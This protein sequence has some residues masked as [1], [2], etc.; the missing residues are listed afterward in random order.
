MKTHLKKLVLLTAIFF[1]L[2]AGRAQAW[3]DCRPDEV[4]DFQP[5]DPATYGHDLLPSIVTGFPGPSSATTGSTQVVSLG[6]GGSITLDFT[7]NIIVNGPGPDFIVFE[8]AFFCGTV[9]GSSADDYSVFVEPVIVEVF[10]GSTWKAFDYDGDALLQVG[11]TTEDATCAPRSLVEQLTGLAGITPTFSGDRIVPDDPH[12]WDPDGIGGVSGWGGDA[13]DLADIGVTQTD[14]IRL[15]DS[16]RIAG[17]TGSPQGADIDAVIALNSVPVIAGGTDS[18]G[19]G[20]S[21][22]DEVAF[23]TDPHNPDT[24]GDGQDDGLE[25]ALCHCP[26]LHGDTAVGVGPFYMDGDRDGD[27]VVNCYDNCERTPNTGQKD[28]DGD[29]LGDACEASY[30]TDKNNPDTDG[31]GE[32]DGIEVKAG[33]NPTNPDDDFGD[34]TDKDGDGMPDWWESET[35]LAT[36]RDDSKEDP[37]S[38]GLTNLEE[39]QCNTNPFDPDTDGDGL[40]DGAELEKGANPTK[41]D[42]SGDSGGGGGSSSGCSMSGKQGSDSLGFLAGIILPLI[43]IGLLRSKS[44]A[45]D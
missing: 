6:T 17:F 5:E 12:V 45:T 9:P 41:A 15:T 2:A 31:G 40:E 29:H 28:S 14:R 30:S 33:R 36:D 43:I 1:I 3:P 23:G 18:D 21:D 19:D 4:Y 25:A 16:G 27:G 44:A 13:F 24:D 11:S 26:L 7:N 37:D 42:Q 35:G 10:D 38:D 20:L 8:N 22:A 39:Y 32:L 34:F